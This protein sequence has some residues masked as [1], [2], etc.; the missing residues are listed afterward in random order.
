MLWVVLLGF[1]SCNRCKPNVWVVCNFLI[2]SYNTQNAAIY[3]I[4]LLSSSSTFPRLFICL[5]RTRFSATSYQ[6]RVC[7]LSSV[8]WYC[9]T[10][11]IALVL[12]GKC[13]INPD[14]RSY[15]KRCAHRLWKQTEVTSNKHVQLFPRKNTVSLPTKITVMQ[16]STL[17]VFCS[18]ELHFQRSRQPRV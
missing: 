7:C 16:L 6:L 14:H 11:S 5:S 1:C 10:P 3:D 12:R 9:T 4:T 2:V 15:W 17:V 13:E 18:P 8:L